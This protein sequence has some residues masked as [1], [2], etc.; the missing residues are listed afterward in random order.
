MRHTLEFM[1]LNMFYILFLLEYFNKV[2]NLIGNG[3][4]IDPVIFKKEIESLNQFEVIMLQTFNF[5]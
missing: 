5:K 4:I 3:F 1:E 2:E